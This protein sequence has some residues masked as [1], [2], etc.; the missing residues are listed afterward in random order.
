MLTDK[1]ACCQC[2][3]LLYC[4]HLTIIITLSSYGSFMPIRKW[5]TLAKRNAP[6]EQINKFLTHSSTGVNYIGVTMLNTLLTWVLS[7]YL[8]T[9]KNTNTRVTRHLPRICSCMQRRTTPSIPTT[10]KATAYHWMVLHQSNYWLV[11]G[12]YVLQT[13]LCW[14]HI[15]VLVQSLC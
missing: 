4:L 13:D 5:L 6:C 14:L 15:V 3:L 12:R 10:K 7:S 8:L 2:S 11:V 1:T 9:P